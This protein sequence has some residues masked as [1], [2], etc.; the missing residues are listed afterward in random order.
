MSKSIVISKASVEAAGK[1]AEIEKEN[2]SMPWSENPLLSQ[3]SRTTTY[4]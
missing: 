3:W 1:I 2:F 4:F